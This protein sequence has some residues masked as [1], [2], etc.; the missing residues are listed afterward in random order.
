VVDRQTW[1]ENLS[2][3][4]DA[5]RGAQRYKQLA[6][7]LGT[8]TKTAVE[9]MA[10][11]Q[12]IIRNA[13][14]LEE[15][16]AVVNEYTRSINTVEGYKT[17]SK[18]GL[19]VG[20]TIATGGGSL[21]ALAGSS[22]SVATAGAVIVGGVDC[23]VDVGQTTS[24]IILGEDH[25]VTVDLKK[26]ADVIQPV[27]MVMGLVTMDPSSAVEQV[28]FLGE[29]MM[30][31]SYP[32]KVTGMAVEIT[33][34]GN[35]MVLARLIELMGENIPDVERTLEGLNL[36][37]PK[38]EGVALSELILA[39]TVDSEAAL[40]KMQAL[41]VQIAALGQE[42]EAQIQPPQETIPPDQEDGTL[43]GEQPQDMGATEKVAVYE[44]RNV[45][46][47]SWV[48]DSSS[49]PEYFDDLDAID[50]ADYTVAPGGVVTDGIDVQAR[51]QS[52]ALIELSPKTYS[53]TVT[54]AAYA[55]TITG[56]YGESAVIE[57][58]GTSFTQV[59]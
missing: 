56:V 18:V 8:D 38:E 40:A 11:A 19:F 39:N 28:A 50:V 54:C 4:Y 26:A 3:Q 35:S 17:T 41:G 9:Q 55:V 22:M 27:S 48:I 20:A 59:K 43:T 21:T 46:G 24:S 25:Q 13:A 29:A 16:Q 5:L 14:D 7:Q 15:A 30:E 49:D 47:T 32:G 58:D 6:Q 53:I 33:K 31:W 42:E 37:F 12:K 44:I 23:I 36:A 1:A 34:R 10:L 57:W 51:L 2:K 52:G 45:S